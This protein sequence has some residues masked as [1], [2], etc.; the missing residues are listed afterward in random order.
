VGE[1]EDAAEA[2][3]D[4]LA[5][6]ASEAQAEAARVVELCKALRLAPGVAAASNADVLA[7]AL[8][9]TGVSIVWAEEGASGPEVQVYV[10]GRPWVCASDGRQIMADLA[11]R[12]MLRKLAATGTSASLSGTLASRSSSTGR[13]RGRVAGPRLGRLGGPVWRLVT[14]AD[15]SAV[16]VRSW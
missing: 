7:S 11:I 3:I 6:E 9:G 4:A 5:V 10:D 14:S 12:L 1:A 13:K 15:V 16:E 2:R 8:R